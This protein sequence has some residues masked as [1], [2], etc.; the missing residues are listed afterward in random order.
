MNEIKNQHI[1]EH[2]NPIFDKLMLNK[3]GE[4]EVKK[5]EATQRFNEFITRLEMRYLELTDAENNI[6]NA[7]DQTTQEE[8]KILQFI[9]VNRIESFFQHF[10]AS[11]SAFAMYINHISNQEFKRGM[12]I[13]GNKKF[14]EF[15]VKKFPDLTK[16]LQELEKVRDFRS[17]FI[18]HIQQ[19]TLC[20]WMT[21]AHPSKNGVDSGIIYFIKKGPE[22]YFTGM[23]SPHDPNFKPPVNCDVFWVSPPHK[24]SWKLLIK[25]IEKVIKEI[26]NK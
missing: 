17:K 25:T 21:Y 1:L 4:I 2:L 9:F 12:S 5:L 26:P 11:L 10:Y 24:Q 8:H 20:D 16:D 18:D 14:I 3:K 15:L 23:T 19:R 22:I 7:G 13:K 6:F